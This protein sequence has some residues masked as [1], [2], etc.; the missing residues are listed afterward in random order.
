MVLHG[1]YLLGYFFM[2][3]ALPTGMGPTLRSASFAPGAI[4]PGGP[5][6]IVFSR[7]YVE[8]SG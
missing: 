8:M 4:A 5:V 7:M 3:G 2:V 1:E 6:K